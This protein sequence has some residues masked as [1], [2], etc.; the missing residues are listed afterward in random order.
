MVRSGRQI[1][2]AGEHIV[3][4]NAVAG[5]RVIDHDVGDRPNR[6]AVPDEGATAHECVQVGTTVFHKKLKSQNRIKRIKR[7]NVAK[8]YYRNLDKKHFLW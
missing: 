2:H 3:D 4:E 5:G 1:P 8:I 7:L 6:L